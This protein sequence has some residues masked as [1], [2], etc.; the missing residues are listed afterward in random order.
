MDARI[1][2]VE[3]LKAGCCRPDDGRPRR[4]MVAGLAGLLIFGLV[5]TAVSDEATNA[6][7]PV[8]EDW[9]TDPFR[10]LENDMHVVE[11]DLDKGDTQKP[12]TVE[13]P[14]ILSRMDRLIETL[15]QARNAAS[16]AAGSS[17]PTT[18]AADSSLGG[19]PGGEGAMRS[20]GNSRRKWA[21]LTPKQREK[22]LQSRDQG[23]PSGYKDILQ[24]YFLRLSQEEAVEAAAEENDASAPSN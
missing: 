12:V 5:D 20:P 23:F 24:E 13:Q 15:S 10:H 8:P 6:P 22:I 2:H 4:I 17:S 21:D 1:S 18:P 7:L 11:G 16:G 19:G 14:R 9:L 3:P